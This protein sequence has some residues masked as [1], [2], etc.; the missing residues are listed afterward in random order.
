[1]SIF[2]GLFKFAQVMPARLNAGLESTEILNN[3]GLMFMRY[4]SE[5]GGEIIPVSATSSAFILFFPLIS[6]FFKI[7]YESFINIFFHCIFFLSYF[8]SQYFI[9]ILN[10]KIFPKF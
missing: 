3:T 5:I 1:M 9:Y 10:K 6:N 2:E 4:A 8:F 7:E